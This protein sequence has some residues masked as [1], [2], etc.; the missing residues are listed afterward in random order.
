MGKLILISTMI[1]L[2]VLG[3]GYFNRTQCLGDDGPQQA[4]LNYFSAMKSERFEKAYQ[5]ITANMASEKTVEAWAS[6][7]RRVF[8]IGKVVINKIDVRESYRTLD[9]I[10]M[11]ANTAKVSNVLHAS[12]VFNNQGS[13]EFEV[14]TLTL[15]DGMW[16]IDSQETLFDDVLIQQWFPNDI[17][18]EFKDTLIP[19]KAGT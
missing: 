5:F 8:A 3:G 6:Q 17:L 14:Y 10:F 15:K 16:K 19:A 1:L 18:P 12:D 11:C 2:I 9:N 13:S 7:Q 4:V